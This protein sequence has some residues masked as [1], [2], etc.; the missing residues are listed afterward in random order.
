MRQVLAVRASSVE[1]EIGIGI[2]IEGLV[3][4]SDFDTDFDK[5]HSSA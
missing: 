2:G 5:H 1:I 4:R 3:D